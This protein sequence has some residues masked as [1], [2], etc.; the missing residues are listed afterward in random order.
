MM[1]KKILIIATSQIS[2][3]SFLIPHIQKL[4]KKFQIVVVTNLVS[5]NLKSIRG[6]KVLNL[7]I[8]RKINIF[9]DVRNLIWILNYLR[10]NKF[11]LLF[12]IT[13]KAGLLGMMAGFFWRIPIRIHIFTGQVWANKSLFYKSFLKL[14]DKIIFYLSTEILC[15]SLNQK[16]FLIKNGFSKNIKVIHYGSVC[17]IDSEL[18]KPSYLNKKRLRKK[19]KVF[20]KEIVFLHVGRLNEDKGIEN[21]IEVFTRLKKL[22][23]HVRFFFIGNSES[24]KLKEKIQGIKGLHFISHKKDIYK[25]YQFGD[26]F[27]TSTFREGFGISVAQAMSTKLPIIGTSIYGLKDLLKP[28]INS[29]I[30]NPNDIKKLLFNCKILLN[31]KKKRIKLGSAGRKLIIDKFDQKNVI[32]EYVKFFN[33]KLN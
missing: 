25:Y 1:K 7:N 29:L 3:E 21:I 9:N 30:H 26:I 14:F 2:I 19:Y 28:K 16:Y 17:G 31:N 5:A 27:I 24:V 4:K 12:T 20:K 18:Y 8:S 22:N 15:D 23:Y 33:N 10:K 6:I 32:N 13:P 11:S